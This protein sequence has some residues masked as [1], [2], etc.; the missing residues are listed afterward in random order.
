MGTTLI[1]I[2]LSILLKLFSIVGFSPARVIRFHP[3]I[4]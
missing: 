3:F 2:T 4:D 1:F